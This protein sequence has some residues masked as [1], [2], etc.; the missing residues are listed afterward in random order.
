MG[1]RVM[2]WI[3]PLLSA[4]LL[5]GGAT[6]LA[7]S[8]LI[9]SGDTGCRDIA[10]TYDVEFSSTTQ[11]L[12]DTV[13]SLGIRTTWFFL[14]DSVDAYPEIVRQ[15]ALRHFIAN[16]TLNHL[17]LTRYSRAEIRRQLL[18]SEANI[19]RVSGYNPSP[20]WRP[21]YGAYDSDV[22]E[23]AE[24]A[25]YDY[26]MMWSIDT[27]DWNGPSVQTI[28]RRIVDNAEPGAI[29]LQHGFPVN[30]IEAT[31][32]AV[33][34]LREMGYQ[35]VTIPEILDLTRSQRDF[36]GDTYVIQ[37]GDSFDFIGRCHNVTGPRVQAYN[38]LD[39]IPPGI[40]LQI[41]HVDEIMVRLD[42]ERIPFPV[43]PRLAGEKSL[44]HVRLAERL[45]ADVAWDGARV[46]ITSANG[47][48]IEITPGERMAL[49]NGAPA[50]MGAAAVMV[51][52]RV[53]APVRFLA[54]QLGRRVTWEH[55]TWT[56]LV[57]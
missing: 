23:V 31:R 51:D 48:R 35:F 10:L 33:G 24:E 20:F 36:G 1:I 49:V 6:A 52:D 45:G 38:D 54:E 42:G 47:K 5:L 7:Q 50:D 34:D 11:A 4:S 56:V 8:R 43:Y 57:R 44:V 32:L 18:Q 17:E 15:V 16:H 39:D 27:E 9:F 3:A 28:R 14:G 21:P 12:A 26:T 55:D 41:P 40:A 46:I 30:S 13:D 37:N 2:R 22:L 19:E 53:L 29:V 25:G